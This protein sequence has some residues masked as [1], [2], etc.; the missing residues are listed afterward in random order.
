VG[1]SDSGMAMQPSVN[2]YYQFG[3]KFP[4]SVSKH[5]CFCEVYHGSHS[6]KGHRNKAAVSEAEVCPSVRAACLVFLSVFQ[7]P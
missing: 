6:D 1:A 2:F 5:T 4:P 7:F 3:R